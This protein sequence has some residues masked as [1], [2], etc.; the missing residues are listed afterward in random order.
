MEAMDRTLGAAMKSA[1]PT[2]AE[3]K[4]TADQES[5]SEFYAGA[6]E[7]LYR[8]LL[9]T[10]RSPELAEDAVHEAFARA[11]A[12]WERVSAH[13][14]PTAWLARVAMNQA[15]SW[16]RRRRRERPDPPDRPARADDRPVDAELVR[17]VWELPTRQRQVV[18]LR[19]L[20]DQSTDETGRVLGIAPGTVTAHLHR[21][22][23]TLRSRLVEA[24]IEELAN[25]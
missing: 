24:G 5:F 10:T 7:P 4:L 13:P 25:A 14:N 11:F 15:T 17:V 9:L 2:P 18:A 19:I 23:G 21:A 16:W 8:T 20:L 3:A 22:L 12:D 6:R 1:A